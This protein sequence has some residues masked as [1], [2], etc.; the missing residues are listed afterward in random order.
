[1]TTAFAFVPAAPLRNVAL[2]M[3]RLRMVI[4][5][6]TMHAVKQSRSPEP[7]LRILVVDDNE[8][9]ANTLSE[10]LELLGHRVNTF[11]DGFS[12]VAAAA[13]LQPD[14][15]V[16]D[17]GMPGM[18][19]LQLAVKLRDLFPQTLLIACT[20]WGAERDRERTKAAG[21]H[22]HVVK[23]AGI[24]ELQPLLRRRAR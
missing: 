23:P 16:L 19:G 22:H 2:S 4:T 12:A 1:V 5:L 18:D 7:G 11:H 20:G 17:I 13:D 24:D 10:M 14:V 3:A 6:S 21:F 15:A 8:D 9:A